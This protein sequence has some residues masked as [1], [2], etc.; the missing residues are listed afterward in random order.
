VPA[1]QIPLIVAGLANVPLATATFEQTPTGSPNDLYVTYR[2]F[3]NVDLWG[4]D[5]GLTLLLTDQVS[6]SGSYSL[7][8]GWIDSENSCENF[9]PNLDGVGDVALNAPRNKAMLAGQYR[10]QRL[11]LGLELRGRYIDSYPV[12]SGV[13]VGQVPSF[14]L[15]DAN[16]TYTLPIITAT[17]ATLTVNN[18][19]DEQ[20]QEMVGA[21]F[22]GRTIMFRLSQSF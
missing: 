17:Q 10:N 20:H 1:E 15:L 5:I 11:G 4:F 16:I 14:T 21:P 2:N 13:F 3:G 9:F 7:A 12:N 22:L 18:V 6:F 8:C 19:F